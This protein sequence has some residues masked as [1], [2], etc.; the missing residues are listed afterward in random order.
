[1]ISGLRSAAAPSPAGRPG[2]PGKDLSTSN[3]VAALGLRQA[4]RNGRGDVQDMRSSLREGWRDVS[5]AE[6]TWIWLDADARRA[7]E[8]RGFPGRRASDL[9]DAKPVGRRQ[10]H[11]DA[12]EVSGGRSGG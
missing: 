5:R 10:R 12:Q 9:S 7:S 3:P 8:A 2:G 6:R 11:A 4:A 1:M